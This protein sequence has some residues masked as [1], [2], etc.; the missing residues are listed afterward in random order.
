MG[1]A[2]GRAQAGWREGAAPAGVCTQAAEAGASPM[3]AAV[4]VEAVAAAPMPCT[5]VPMSAAPAASRRARVHASDGRPYCQPTCGKCMQQAQGHTPFGGE[6]MAPHPQ[7]LTGGEALGSLQVAQL[8]S[9]MR[10]WVQ[11]GPLIVVQRPELRLHCT[12]SRKTEEHAP[13]TISPLAGVRR[14]LSDPHG[15]S[16]TRLW[17]GQPTVRASALRHAIAGWTGLWAGHQGAWAASPG[18]RSCPTC[19][20]VRWRWVGVGSEALIQWTVARF[21]PPA[22]GRNASQGMLT[23]RWASRSRRSGLGFQI[24]QQSG[25]CYTQ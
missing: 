19:L 12:R 21:Q 13:P 9:A 22:G 4:L 6:G 14:G 25:M 23:H 20:Q 3:G 10:H 16:A 7:V 5:P 8:P 2:A 15:N 1:W 18:W 17:G 24:C 11:P